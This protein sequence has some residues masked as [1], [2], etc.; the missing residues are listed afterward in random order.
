MFDLKDKIIAIA[1]VNGLIGSVLHARFL[2]MGAVVIP[3]RA[4][5]VQYHDA[6]DVFVNCIYDRDW[7]VHLSNFIFP[8]RQMAD[9]M[10]ENGGGSIINFSSIYGI[11]A[12]DKRSYNGTD[13]WDQDEFWSYSAVK[14]GVI[15]VTRTAAAEYA[16]KHVRINSICPGGVYDGQP[17]IFV[18]SYCNR[19]PMGRMAS[20]DD[21]VGSVA[22][23]ASDASAYV[24]GQ[25]LV[26]DGGLTLW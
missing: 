16:P 10:A 14:G 18:E 21:I 20:P 6:P 5:L 24:T 17:Q 22:F 15:A 25:N 26:V 19:V 13:M 2:E 4:E 7:I 1:G 11:V 9:L 8:T 23:L 12:P 3:R